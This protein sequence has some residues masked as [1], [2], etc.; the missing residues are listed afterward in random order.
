M[1]CMLSP[2][3]AP[4][5]QDVLLLRIPS[6]GSYHTSDYLQK[7]S[8]V[9]MSLTHSLLLKRGPPKSSIYHTEETTSRAWDCNICLPYVYM[10]RLNEN[11]NFHIPENPIAPSSTY[12]QR[13]QHMSI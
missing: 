4:K 1:M 11:T 3:I 9:T 13:A 10:R 6:S 8:D 12:T 5:V 2:S 7:S